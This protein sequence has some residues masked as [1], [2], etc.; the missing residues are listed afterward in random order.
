ME[1]LTENDRELTLIDRNGQEA[2][3]MADTFVK[4]EPIFLLDYQKDY[5]MR[6]RLNHKHQRDAS[7]FKIKYVS[8]K[9]SDGLELG[10][11]VFETSHQSE[12]N[13]VV[14]LFQ[15]DKFQSVRLS[16]P[17]PVFKLGTVEERYVSLPITIGVETMF[18]TT[19][20]HSLKF[21]LKGRILCALATGDDFLKFHS[22]R[23][24]VLRSWRNCPQ[25]MRDAARGAIML[26]SM[27]SSNSMGAG[28]IMCFLGML[29]MASSFLVP[30]C[31]RLNDM[32]VP[33]E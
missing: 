16:S 26:G 29:S 15:C 21:E 28:L 7:N 9:P 19:G 1:K 17:S 32:Q 3:L 18:A 5:R 30:P 12:G 27:A 2:F 33:T 13:E 31:F 14:A 10:L 25:W 8:V 4:G 24:F 23:R 20:G 22:L 11:K 6:V